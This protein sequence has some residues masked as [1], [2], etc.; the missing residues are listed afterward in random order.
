[1]MCSDGVASARGKTQRRKLNIF[2]ANEDV[3]FL[4]VEEMMLSVAEAYVYIMFEGC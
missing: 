3:F 2:V 4:A 1:M